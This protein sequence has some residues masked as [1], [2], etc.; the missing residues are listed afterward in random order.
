MVQNFPYGILIARLLMQNF[1]A[2][3]DW[4]TPIED[5][6]VRKNLKSVG[7]KTKTFE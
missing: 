3:A 2:S 4:D 5:N 7:E 1:M 6:I